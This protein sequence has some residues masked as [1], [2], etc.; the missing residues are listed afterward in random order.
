VV[1]LFAARTR[2]VRG[3]LVLRWLLPEKKTMHICAVNQL[4]CNLLRFL[5][6]GPL[7]YLKSVEF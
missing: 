1:L 3:K 6:L 4:V 7:F 2:P 5:S